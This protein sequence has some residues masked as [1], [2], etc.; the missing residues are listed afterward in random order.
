MLGNHNI[1]LAGSINGSFSD[2]NVYTGYSFLKTR[3]NMGGA[4][5]QQPIYQYYGSCYNCNQVLPG[6]PDERVDTDVF[7]RDLTRAVQAM[8]AYPFNTYQRLEFSA[9][10]AYRRQDWLYRGVNLSRGEALNETIKAGSAKYLQPSAA[11]VF[12]NSLFGYTGPIAGR[13]YRIE[14]SQVLGD[15]R[16]NEGLVDFRNYMNYKQKVV[17]ATRLL[18]LTRIGEH[19]DLFR[20]FWGGPYFLRGYNQES[21]DFRSS[22]CQTSGTLSQCAARDQLIGSSAALLSTELRFPIIKEL[23]IGFLGNFPPVDAVAFF[24]AG[25]AWTNKICS[26]GEA[27]ALGG[28]VDGQDVHLVWKRK[29]GQDPLLYRQPLYSYGVGLRINVFFTI[30]RLDYAI[31]LSRSDRSGRFTVSFGPSF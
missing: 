26:G 2:A 11:L 29:E 21:F 6:R 20:Y 4:L 8:A 14:A 7:L 28:C 12:D 22:E 25:L 17:L 15:F 18:S 16:F 19:A 3:M 9:T 10:A 27:I 31:P 23:Q 30:L 5:I 24:D 13:R 1:L